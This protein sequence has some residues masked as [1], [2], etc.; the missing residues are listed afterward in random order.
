MAGHGGRTTASRA[1]PL[2]VGLMMPQT[3]GM[4]GRGTSRWVQIRELAQL[5]EDVGFDSLWVVDHFLYQLQGDDRPRGVWECWSLLSALAACTRTAE[6]GTLVLGLGFRNPALLAKMADTVDEISDGRLIL[7]VGAGYHEVEYRAFGYPF[8]HR[9]SRFEEAIQIVHGLLRQ[10][11]VDFAGKY[12][13]ARDC[14]L[15]PRG[16]RKNGPPIMIGS[17]RPRMLGLLARY[18]DS[19][20]GYYDDTGNTLEGVQRLRDVV[21]SACGAAGRDPATV[22]RTIT[23]L[24][25]DPSADPWWNRLP[26]G[27]ELAIKPL[28]GS[29]Q[30]IADA[31]RAFGCEGIA[32]VQI[33]LEPTTPQSIAAFAPVLQQLDQ[34]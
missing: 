21:D 26:V 29:P 5:A 17:I 30:H 33:A 12:H 16:P 28:S 27:R 4:R 2:K 15:R 31:L 10:G 23:V 14:E 7:G 20:N 8:D 13:Q 24:V 3:D 34:G 32:H 1:R 19:W 6:L 9:V 22:E 18:A 11:H 25:A